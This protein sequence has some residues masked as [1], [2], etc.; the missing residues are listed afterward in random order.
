MTRSDAENEPSLVALDGRIRRRKLRLERM[1]P[2]E[3]FDD[4]RRRLVELAELEA[5]RRDR[6]ADEN[7]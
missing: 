2:V 4:Y 5:Q 7:G 3:Q 6:A 1:N